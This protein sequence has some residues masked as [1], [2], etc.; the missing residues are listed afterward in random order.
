M[1]WHRR[2]VWNTLRPML[3]LKRPPAA[4]GHH[5][6]SLSKNHA[7]FQPYQSHRT[8]MASNGRQSHCH[9]SGG[10]SRCPFCPGARWVLEYTT[11]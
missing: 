6:P 9:S 5:W 10:G 11:S 7:L 3:L 2:V 4:A 1:L 8:P